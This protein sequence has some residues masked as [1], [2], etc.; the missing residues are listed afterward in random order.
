MAV[1]RD[2][3][4]CHSE[5]KSRGAYPIL[6]GPAYWRPEFETGNARG[7]VAKIFG[8]QLLEHGLH[9]IAEPVQRP[10]PR[11]IARDIPAS[12]FGAHTTYGAWPSPAS[13]EPNPSSMQMEMSV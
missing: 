11:L 10:G 5:A 1:E 9:P 12:R 6:H 7:H 8:Q 3:K 2:A 4:L 13:L